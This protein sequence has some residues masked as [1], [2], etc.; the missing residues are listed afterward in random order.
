MYVYCVQLSGFEILMLEL[1]AMPPVY[2]FSSE[3][4]FLQLTH[5]RLPPGAHRSGEA[6][7]R[8]LKYT[9]AYNGK[10]TRQLYYCFCTLSDPCWKQGKIYIMLF[11]LTGGR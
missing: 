7:Y 1:L 5:S 10:L 2:S 3:Q 4:F 6:G 8:A 9:C 11:K